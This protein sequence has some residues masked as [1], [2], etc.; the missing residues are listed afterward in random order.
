MLHNWD[1]L[2]VQAEGVFTQGDLHM[3]QQKISEN[4][5]IKKSKISK[6]STPGARSYNSCESNILK[7]AWLAYVSLQITSNIRIY[8]G[9]TGG[10]GV[11]R[12]GRVVLASSCTT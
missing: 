2:V 8:C 1:L 9:D 7:R 11:K 3:L 4:N 10:G 6:F 12:F 5:I